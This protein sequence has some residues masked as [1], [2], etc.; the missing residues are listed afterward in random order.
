[1]QTNE[2]MLGT[3]GNV[4]LAFWGKNTVCLRRMCSSHSEAVA[5]AFWGR[6]KCCFV[7]Y[8][9]KQLIWGG[10]VEGASKRK[11]DDILLCLLFH[12]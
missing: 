8:V 1:V 7:G 12:E 4:P 2:F 3:W 9:P 6:P 5:A 11:N 10:V